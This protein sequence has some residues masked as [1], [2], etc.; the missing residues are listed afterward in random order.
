MKNGR[1]QFIK[2][3]M[4]RDLIAW[5]DTLS[6]ERT[7]KLRAGLSPDREAAVIAAWKAQKH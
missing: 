4:L 6:A 5:W 7:G 2:A 3:G 1:R